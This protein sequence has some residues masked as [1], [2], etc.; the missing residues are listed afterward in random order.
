MKRQAEKNQAEF[1]RESLG[2]YKFPD[3]FCPPY[4]PLVSMGNLK[5][6]KCRV[7]DSKKVFRK[8]LCPM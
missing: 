6:K 8:L 5:L 4:D 7:M 2:K 3:S 1:A